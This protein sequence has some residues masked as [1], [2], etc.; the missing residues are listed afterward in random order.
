[1][2][3]LTAIAFSASIALCGCA[4]NTAAPTHMTACNLSADTVPRSSV[5]CSTPGRIYTQDEIRQTGKTTLGGA[6]GYLDPSLTV[7]RP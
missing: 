3:R 6:L 2:N 4:T 1:M 7:S 5:G